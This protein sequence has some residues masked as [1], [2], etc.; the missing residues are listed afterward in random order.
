[1]EDLYERG[2]SDTTVASLD[3]LTLN[4]MKE[5]VGSV[6]AS[7]GLSEFDEVRR[8]AKRQRRI[9]DNEDRRF[10]REPVTFRRERNWKDRDGYVDL[11][12]NSGGI[13]LQQRRSLLPK[14]IW[15]NRFSRRSAGEKDVEQRAK[16]EEMERDR[17]A[18][19][20][21]SLL[22]KAGLLV[23]KDEPGLRESQHWLL[24]RHAMGRRPSTL[25]QHVRLGRKLVGYAKHSYGAA[26]FKEP[27]DVMEYV[28]L[29]MEEP[30]GKSVPGSIWATLRFLEESAEVPGEKRISGDLALRN[31]FAE[32]SRHPTWAEG[33]PRSSAKRLTTS[34]VVAWE[35]VVVTSG[36]RN[37]VRI[38]AWFKLIKL[39]AALRWDDTLGIPPSMIDM[40]PEVGLRGKIVRSKTTGEGRRVDLQE[41][42][43]SKDCWLRHPEWLADG[44]ELFNEMGKANGSLGRDFLLPRPDKHLR[45]FRGSMVRYAEA[46]SMARALL[47]LAVVASTSNGMMGHLLITTPDTSGFWSEHSERVTI[48]SWAAAVGVEPEIRKRWGRWKPSTDE[49][50]AK[51]S[52]TM[53][54]EG[55]R[56]L[57]EYLRANMDNKNVVEDDEILVELGAW[58]TQRGIAEEEVQLQVKRLTMRKGPRWRK[59]DGLGLVPR[60]PT[61]PGSPLFSPTEPAPDPA[62]VQ[63]EELADLMIEDTGALPVVPGTFVLSVVG[64][65]KRRTLH[66]V[67]SC[68]RIPG[69]HYKEFM[70]VGDSRPSLEQGE[71]LCATCF[72][73]QQKIFE[74]ASSAAES[75]EA[76]LSSDSSSTSLG[77]TDSDD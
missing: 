8:E 48:I 38:F 36:E 9:I 56:V 27:A 49:E 40:R 30:C 76:E 19:D 31:F 43:V 32:V 75:V 72:G 16:L 26:W 18:N 52:L 13:Q 23:K 10:A 39:W 37:Y 6:G 2:W 69:V 67:G 3:G 15:P 28:A 62:V 66:Q 35:N 71:K 50:Y 7:W 60:S 12:E 33:Q 4:E 1:M 64:R 63:D 57:A 11:S 22:R 29:R 17:L 45:G 59:D 44:W 68:Y 77:D 53:V 65:S 73:K 41:F 14:A 47:N 25:R 55:Q 5:T 24:K 70:V 54:F 34:V 74:E 42:Y 61:S 46:M 58:L 21:V 20:L 51:T